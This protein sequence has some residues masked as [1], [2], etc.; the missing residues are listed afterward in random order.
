MPIENCLNTE[1]ISPFISVAPPHMHRNQK[2]KTSY[3]KS[4]ADSRYTK[5]FVDIENF[6]VGGRAVFDS[7]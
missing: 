3:Y 7:F 4:L 5:K 2:G 1:I 6:P